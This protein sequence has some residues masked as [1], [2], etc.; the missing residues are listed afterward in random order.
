MAKEYDG[1]KAFWKNGDWLRV[2][3][4]PVPIFPE[5]FNNR[6]TSQI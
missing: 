2:F 1:L 4:V 6:P 3:E 5:R